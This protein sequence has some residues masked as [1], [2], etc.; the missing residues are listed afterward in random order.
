[1][2]R[3]ACHGSAV[4]FSDFCLGM[5]LANVNRVTLRNFEFAWPDIQIASVATVV[6]IGGNGRPVTPMTSVSPI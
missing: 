3:S 6:A 2:I 1:M 4:N 5:V